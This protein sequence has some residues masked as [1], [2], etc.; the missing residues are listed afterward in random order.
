M[1]RSA[2]G[3]NILVIASIKIR[4]VTNGTIFYHDSIE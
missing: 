2:K 3:K 1:F 4:G